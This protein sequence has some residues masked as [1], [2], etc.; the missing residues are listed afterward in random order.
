M[1]TFK[2]NNTLEI[3]TNSINSKVKSIYEL[4]DEKRIIGYATINNDIK[5]PIYIYVKKEYR[6]NRLWKISI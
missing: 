2:R 3:D 5:N 4:T 6:G 1:L